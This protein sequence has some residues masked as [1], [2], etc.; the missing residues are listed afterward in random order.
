MSIP[1]IGLVG[2][3]SWA[4]RTHAPALAAHPGV[5]FTGVWGRRPEA[6]AALAAAHG[7]PAHSGEDGF[8]ELLATSDALAFALPPDVQAPLATRAA[9]AGRHLLLDKPIAT[10]VA[11]AR[12]LADAATTAGVASVVFTT[13]RFAPSSAAWLAGLAGRDGWITGRAE[14]F[15]GLYGSDADPS[16][17]SPWR[18][19]KGGLWDVGPHA[20]SVLLA[21]LGDIEAVTAVRGAPDLTHLVLRHASGATSSAA[22]T[23]SAPKAAA[24]VSVT[25]RGTEGVESLPEG[26]DTSVTSFTAA[27]DALLTAI[28]T[29]TPHPCDVRFG[30]RLTELLAQAEGQLKAAGE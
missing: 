23:L 3:G 13:M 28:D 15:G 1:R 8:A 7:V 12:A 5:A 2:S 30:A 21:V 17:D 11:T 16:P 4:E 18:R 14:W 10:E 24:G 22:L 9:E 29:K 19:A 27:I 26:R 20:L 25:F 6:A